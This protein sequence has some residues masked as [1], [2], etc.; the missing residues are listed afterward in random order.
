MIS[1]R[2]HHRSADQ[3]ADQP[4]NAGE[5][6]PP[7]TNVSVAEQEKSLR[8]LID[9]HPFISESAKLALTLILSQGVLNTDLTSSIQIYG[10]LGFL[11]GIPG[12]KLDKPVKS[13]LELIWRTRGSIAALTAA[14]MLANPIGTLDRMYNLAHSLGLEKIKSAIDVICPYDN[15]AWFIGPRT[16]TAEWLTRAVVG[17]LLFKSKLML[18]ASAKIKASEAR[19]EIRRQKELARSTAEKARLEARIAKL[20]GGGGGQS[21]AS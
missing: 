20:E 2:R 11:E 17:Y 21:Q 9:S 12:F 16:F 13:T 4:N 14:P 8:L 5:N 6:I 1:F 7:Q 19:Q 18:L 10:L 3:S 15:D